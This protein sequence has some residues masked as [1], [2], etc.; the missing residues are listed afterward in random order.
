MWSI[1]LLV[2]SYS[3]TPGP[4]EPSLSECCVLTHV[5][6]SFPPQI[7]PCPGSSSVSHVETTHNKTSGHGGHFVI[8]DSRFNVILTYNMSIL[9]LGRGLHIIKS[10]T[11]F[12]WW[13]DVVYGFNHKVLI[14][15]NKTNP[16]LPLLTAE[17][18]SLWASCTVFTKTWIHTNITEKA[19]TRTF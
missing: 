19:S 8:V 17:R 4:L 10:A 15:W 14:A 12:T 2:A 11:P 7:S 6:C 16:Q 3:Q 1:F 5:A 9:S 18:R 13:S